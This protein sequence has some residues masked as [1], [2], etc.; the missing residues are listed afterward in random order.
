MADN[1]NEPV[2]TVVVPAPDAVTEEGWIGQFL[3]QGNAVQYA[4]QQAVEQHELMLAERMRWD[5]SLYDSYWTEAEEKAFWTLHDMTLRAA[6]YFD[7]VKRRVRNVAKEPSSDNI[8]ALAS[9]GEPTFS[10]ANGVLTM[11]IAGQPAASVDAGGFVGG[12]PA[13]AATIVVALSVA[14]AAG[15]Y[16]TWQKAKDRLEAARV[17][18]LQRHTDEC[19]KTHTLDECKALIA[20][21]TNQLVQQ[22]K[23][24]Q[25]TDVSRLTEALQTIA[26]AG[27]V[28]GVAGGA[29]YMVQ[30]L[31][32]RG[33]A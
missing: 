5:L 17:D 15:F 22:S 13:V 14:V 29:V 25:P 23:A 9:V 10:Y 7:E 19:L 24:Q 27:A 16:T 26:I 1:E 11:S 6:A 33:R 20:A 8:V 21:E 12:W 31:W 32:P 18:N 30:K 28:I 2:G 4:W 3:Q